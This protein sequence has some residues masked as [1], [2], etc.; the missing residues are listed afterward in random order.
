MLRTVSDIVPFSFRK[1]MQPLE[2]LLFIYTLISLFLLLYFLCSCFSEHEAVVEVQVPGSDQQETLV[3]KRTAG[4][5]DMGGIS[6]QIAYEVPKTVS[7]ASPQQV[8]I[9]ENFPYFWK[10]KVWHS[11]SLILVLLLV[12]GPWPSAVQGHGEFA[13]LMPWTEISLLHA[14]IAAWRLSSENNTNRSSTVILLKG[15]KFR[16]FWS[17]FTISVKVSYTNNIVQHAL[18][19]VCGFAICFW[20]IGGVLIFCLI[21]IHLYNHIQA[22]SYNLI[23]IVSFR[24]IC[25]ILFRLIRGVSFGLICAVSFRLICAVSFRLNWINLYIFIPNNLD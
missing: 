17:Q 8:I 16:F 1:N 6:T 12:F 10:L 20:W 22:N 18:I 23:H 19:A 7:F 4:V 25:T 3:R 15:T 21:Q 13:E 9:Y 5:L 2:K 14:N 24:L 11:H